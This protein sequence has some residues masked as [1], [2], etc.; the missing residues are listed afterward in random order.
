MTYLHLNARRVSMALNTVHASAPRNPR[1]RIVFS[2]NNCTP[3]LSGRHWPNIHGVYGYDGDS[4]VAL[5][6]V[7]YVRYWTYAFENGED[8]GKAV[9]NRKATISIFKRKIASM[10]NIRILAAL[11]LAGALLIA[12]GGNAGAGAISPAGLSRIQGLSIIGFVQD[13]KK[14]ETMKHKVTRIWRNLTDYKFDV[15]CP[16]FPFVLS[17]TSCTA[18]GKSRE[19]A[20]A[21]CQSQ[22]AFCEVRDANR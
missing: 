6:Q 7:N 19:T 2:R 17:V 11:A 9:A 4:T 10:Q 14:P 15:A 1:R 8:R 18:T 22:H 5:I 20:R 3:A 21:K 16:A 13:K 12:P